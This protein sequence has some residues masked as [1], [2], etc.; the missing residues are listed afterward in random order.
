MK[1]ELV[2]FD[3]V[4]FAYA[5]EPVVDDVSLKIFEKDFIGLVGQNGSGKTTLLKLMIGLLVPQSGTISHT[6]R[7]VVGYVPQKSAHTEKHFPITCE[8]LVLQGRVAKAGLFRMFSWKD[9]K[10]ASEAL[11]AVGLLAQKDKL[12]RELSG[13]Q[14]Q[15][16]FIAR[17][18]ASEPK[19]LILDEPTVGIDE[20]SQEE[21]Y[22]LL[23]KLRREKNLAIII[24]SHDVEVV[25][26]EVNSVLCM[27]K[28]LVYHG[29]IDTFM[30][31]NY[32]EQ[33]F[34]KGKKFIHHDH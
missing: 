4:T 13:G 10:K 26:R 15:R 25:L 7:A 1:K 29:G 18:L 6:K 3:H 17:A 24:V 11:D 19:L 8:E 12:L 34:G 20:A 16:V 21:F 31:G 22:I 5:D 30:D 9:Y 27:N 33:L 14:Q 2:T 28:K 32:T 23:A